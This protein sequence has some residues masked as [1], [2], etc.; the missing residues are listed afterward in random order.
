MHYVI[1]GQRHS[2]KAESRQFATIGQGHARLACT[3]RARAAPARVHFLGVRNDVCRLLDELTL[4]V[5]PARQEPL[6]RVLLE[7]A[8][9][10]VAVIATDVGGTPEIFPPDNTPP[11]S[12]RPTMPTPWPTPFWNCSAI[13]RCGAVWPPPPAAV[14]KS[15]STSRYPSPACSSTI[16]SVRATKCSVLP[17]FPAACHGDQTGLQWGYWDL[18]PLAA[19][20]C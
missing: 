9:A 17:I 4:L 20:T 14:P 8:A 18:R 1:V 10:G 19:K 7:A 3:Q 5:H 2:E 11:G 16:A 6:G 12:C 15:S 13:R